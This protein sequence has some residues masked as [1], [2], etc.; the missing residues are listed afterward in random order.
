M[1]NCTKCG[2]SLVDPFDLSG[3]SSNTCQCNTGGLVIEGGALPSDTCCVSSVNGKTG[4][5]VLT[6]SD[7]DLLGNLFF[8][9]QLVY[10]SL[11][12][13]Y[14]IVFDQNS[15]EISHSPS[16]VVAGVYGSS[17]E[18]PVL[19]V[20]QWGHITAVTPV[21]LGSFTLGANLTAL[22]ALTGTGYLVRTGTNTWVLRSLQ[23]AAGRI[24]LSDPDG[25]NNPTIIDLEVTGVAAGTYGGVTS[26]PVFTVDAYG[27]ILSATSQAIPPAVI[28]AHTHTLGDLSN[29]DDDV[30]TAAA[31]GDVLTWDNGTSEWTYSALSK[32]EQS[33]ITLT[34]GWKFCTAT[35]DV[36]ATDMDGQLSL[37][38]RHTDANDRRQVSI[39]AAV[40]LDWATVT[41]AMSGAPSL[42]WGE[43]RIGDVPV[44]YEPIH[45]TTFSC[46]A[47]VRGTDYMDENASVGFDGNYQ[48]FSRLDVVIRANRAIYLLIARAT[49]YELLNLA[50]VDQVIVPIVGTYPT[51]QIVP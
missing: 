10:S 48:V 21:S 1:S 38:Q 33:V 11:T 3:V 29:V 15:G 14:P 17:T 31:D 12:G 44:G 27:R 43:I 22:N 24:A 26:F 34:G 32:Y 45:N 28:P 40:Y 23:A 30:D 41:A 13:T 2:G 9:N 6:I 4:D 42:Y 37:I 16:G 7:I 18:V 35:N 46:A 36:D 20:D 47:M 49:D 39:N 5:V 19:T 51:K 25:V 8:T 50:T